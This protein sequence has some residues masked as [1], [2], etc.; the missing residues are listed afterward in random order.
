MVGPI[1]VW[2]TM[3]QVAE[4]AADVGALDLAFTIVSEIRKKF[5]DSQRAMR[6]TVCT[7]ALG[8]KSETKKPD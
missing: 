1:A 7:H 4:A 5:P 8:R 6:I 3:E 2:T